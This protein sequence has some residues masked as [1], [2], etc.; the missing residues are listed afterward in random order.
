MWNGLRWIWGRGE[1]SSDYT[2]FC[3]STDEIIW[4]GYRFTRGLADI[5]VLGPV[6]CNNRGFCTVLVHWSGLFILNEHIRFVNAIYTSG[7]MV[8]CERCWKIS[9]WWDKSGYD[10]FRF[11][12]SCVGLSDGCLSFACHE[13]RFFCAKIA[14][15]HWWNNPTA[16]IKVKPVGCLSLPAFLFMEVHVAKFFCLNLNRV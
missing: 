4:Q 15:D 10:D 1:L 11:L 7:R 13:I 12:M 6:F 16:F 9:A 8:N 5:L 14:F 3:K 2:E